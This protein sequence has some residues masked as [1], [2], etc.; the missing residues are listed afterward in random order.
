VHPVDDLLHCST[1]GSAT[2]AATTTTSTGADQ[3][4]TAAGTTVNLL[5]RPPRT[6]PA[7]PRYVP[8]LLLMTFRPG[9]SAQQQ[10][11][12]LAEAGVTVV[13]RI[14]GLGVVVVHVPAAHRDAALDR[15]RA[16]RVVAAAQK[17]TVFE[18]LDT[19]PNDADWYAQWGLRRISMPSV[20]DRTRGSNNVVV[21]VLD[22][23]VASGHPDLQGAILPGYN[24]VDPAK[25]PADD[26]GHG[27]AVAGIIAARTN[28]HEG[29][30]GVCWTCSILPIKVLAAD[31]TGDT[32]RVAA[33]VVRAADAGAR[34]ISMSLGGPGADRTLDDAIAYALGKGA[35]V[36]A[37]AGNN[38]TSSLFYPA[39]SPGV[40]S[41][42]ASDESDHLYSWSNFGS[43][44]QIAAPGCNAA[45]APVGGYVLF[46]GT[47]SATP[48]VA[49]L[50]ALLLSADPNASRTAVVN[51]IETTTTPIGDGVT[52][53]RIDA[54]NALSALV[55]APA[56]TVSPTVLTASS[57]L[58]STIGRRVYRRTIG[59]GPV[60]AAL[61][62]SGASALALTI[63]NRAG[64][65]VASVAGPS[66]L[67]L[68]NNL[69]A[70]RFSFTVSGRTTKAA[71]TLFLTYSAE[72]SRATP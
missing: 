63:R 13:R 36:V 49:G 70:G 35:I 72:A 62:F 67:R 61:T 32:A 15:L 1:T 66:P 14:H 40:V 28:N 51:A 2:T 38:G 41:V 16:S 29:I 48:V 12:V 54:R 53:G 46:C 11:N 71:F 37:A 68:S 43:W 20:W 26:N 65:V 4:A 50:A 59:G 69:P 44:V 7:A 60:T 52:H 18:Q 22:T 31:G 23:G 33:G 17:D 42:A 57:T 24:L 10:A 55:G 64:A 27:T 5:E 58:T 3:P 30:A 47:S 19:T 45:P 9:T 25:P 34:V 6:I 39:A 56:A 8:D 21:A